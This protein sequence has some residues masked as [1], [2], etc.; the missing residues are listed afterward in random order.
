VSDHQRHI[1]GWR[2]ALA[3][4]LAHGSDDAA[5]VA[6]ADQLGAARIEA[7]IIYSALTL[8]GQ[9][10]WALDVDDETEALARLLAVLGDDWSL[11]GHL[12]QAPFQPALVDLDS[13]TVLCSRRCLNR[14]SAATCRPQDAGLCRWCRSYPEVWPMLVVVLARCW[15]LAGSA[16]QDCRALLA[17]PHPTS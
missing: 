8:G 13:E 7:E 17:A 12:A 6:V 3:D 2:A 15:V 14:R 4:H 1:D 11:C 5:V 10:P 16:C 9:R